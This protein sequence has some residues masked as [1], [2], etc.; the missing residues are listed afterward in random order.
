MN[1][2]EVCQTL[3]REIQKLVPYDRL[4]INLPQKDENY[5]RVY[6]EESRL[7]ASAI[8]EG[9]SV[10]EGTASGWVLDHH[11]PVI[12]RDILRDFRFPLTHERYKDVGLRSYVIL[13]LMAKGKALGVLNLA[14]LKPRCYGKKQ[15]EI[16]SPIAEILAVAVENSNLY[17]EAQ[18]REET[19]RLLKEL[20][21]DITTLDVDSLLRK[22]TD[23]V[24]EVF[25]VDVSDVRILENS[26]WRVLAAS[27]VQPGHLWSGNPEPGPGRS[28]WIIE[29]RTPLLIPD[30]TQCSE[31][32]SGANLPRLGL[33]GYLGVPLVSRSGEIAG[34]LR[35]L[36]YQPRVFIQEE[37]DLLQQLANGAALVLENARLFDEVRQKSED[38]E[39]INIRL[40]RLLREQNALREIFT[41][42]NLLDLGHLLHQL[43]EHALSLL[44]VDHAQVRLLGEDGALRT[45]AFAGKESERFRQYTARSGSGRST[46]VMQNRRPFA[47][48]DVSQD[49]IFGPGRLLRELGAKG[50]LVVPLISR[51]EKSIGVLSVSTEAEREFSQEEIAL[52]QQLAAGAAIAIENAGLFEEVQKKSADLEEAFKTKTDF[53]NSMA[54]ELRTPLNVMIG[55]QQLLIEGSYGDLAEEQRKALERIGRHSRNLLDL[56]NEILDLM[57]LE[58]RKVPMHTE[59]FSVG[60][61]TDDLEVFFDPLAREKGL[62]LKFDVG[63]GMPPLKSDRS[64]IRGILQNLL[65]NALK[66]TDRGKV[67]LRVSMQHPDGATQVRRVSWSVRDTGIGIREADLPRLFEPFYMGEGMDRKKYPGTGL[68]L[69]I[70]KRLVELLKGEIRVESE[71]GKGSTFTVAIPVTHSGNG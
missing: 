55:S 16:L 8:P 65:A 17:E 13:P 19:Q 4:A 3:S 53:V 51:G 70:V 12:C 11:E 9:L 28:R 26:A 39:A 5:F 6:A 43:S 2:K 68:G 36:T 52:A 59:E 25:K 54:H 20:N 33:R 67:E 61:L 30:I 24:C 22:L 14:S 50:Y 7:L 29:N 62:E 18:R 64:K 45:V 60:D 49:N 21:Q 58:T 15:V 27:G 35:A 71:W 32:T 66:Y 40:N 57:R 23:K 10:R 1:L 56:I 42:I 34:V 47:A 31:F 41:R 46:W 38:L 48:K 63:D 37:V 44:N 69:S